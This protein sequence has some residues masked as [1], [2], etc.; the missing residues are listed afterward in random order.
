MYIQW[1]LRFIGFPEFVCFNHLTH[2][3]REYIIHMYI[4]TDKVPGTDI[5]V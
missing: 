5:T 2:T 1:L 3:N 4:M